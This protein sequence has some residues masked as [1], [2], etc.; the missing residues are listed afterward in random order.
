MKILFSLYPLSLSLSLSLWFESLPFSVPWDMTL[1]HWV[2]CHW[3]S[4]HLSIHLFYGLLHANFCWLTFSH[5]FVSK[6]P[7][8]N[9]PKTWRRNPGERLPQ[10]GGGESI[11]APNFFCLAIYSIFCIGKIAS[12][13]LLFLSLCSSLSCYW[14]C[15]SLHIEVAAKLQRL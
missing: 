11:E 2:T 1:Y 7:E 12:R 8:T 14:C 5:S 10:L 9:Y 15:S 6:R 3:L 13:R 4:I